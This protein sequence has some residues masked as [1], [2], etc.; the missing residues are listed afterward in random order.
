MELRTFIKNTLIDIVGAIKDAQSEI[1]GN[2]IVPDGVSTNFKSIEHG[3]S[4][5]QSIDFE[6]VVEVDES[7]GTEGKLGVVSSF[8]GAG[9]AGKSS[10]DK[11][12]SNILKFR[13]P[14]QFPTSGSLNVNT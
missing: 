6:I 5:L 14:I 12:N 2:V 8:V 4:H 11:R 10:A 7:K 9:I 13:I 1:Q 3:V